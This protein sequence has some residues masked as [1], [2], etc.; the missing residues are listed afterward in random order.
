[1]SYDRDMMIHGRTFSAVLN[2]RIEIFELH[3][4]FTSGPKQITIQMENGNSI[5]T[6]AQIFDCASISE[7]QHYAD[8]LVASWKDS[9]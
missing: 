4:S 8:K 3:S 1:M 9:F 2:G 5:I 7:K 6:E